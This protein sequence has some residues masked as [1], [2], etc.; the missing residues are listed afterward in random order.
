MSKARVLDV[1]LSRTTVEVIYDCLVYVQAT[2]QMPNFAHDTVRD[3]LDL[4]TLYLSRLDSDGV[5]ED[6][7]DWRD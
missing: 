2:A 3:V 4:F 5:I 6:R 7:G 1:C